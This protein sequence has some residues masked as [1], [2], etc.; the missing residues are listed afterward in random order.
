MELTK[1]LRVGVIGGGGIAQMMHLPFLAKNADRFEILALCDLSPKILSTIGDRF[2]V[3]PAMRFSSHL[4]LVRQDLDVVV[5]TSGGDHTPQVKAALEAGKHVFVEKPL[6]YSLKEV[7]EMSALAVRNDLKVMIGYMKRY[8]PGYHYAKKRLLEMGEIRY[9]Q[10]NTLHPE[11]EGYLKIHGLIA[12]DDVPAGVMQEI[13]QTQHQRILEAVGAIAPHLQAEY[14]DVLLGSM[15]HDINALRGLVGEPERVLFAEHWP[16]GEK[17]GGITTTIQYPGALRVV[18]TW[19]FLPELRNYFQEIALMSST[20]RL[21]IQFPSPYLRNFPTPVVVE[22]MKDGAAVEEKVIVSY[23]EAFEQELLA[24]YECVV[25]NRSP[26][27]DLA[28]AR[29]DIILLQQILAALHPAGLGGEA[30]AKSG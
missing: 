9:V 17:P 1:K 13:S 4:D 2:K 24:F 18:Y 29:R 15:I 16:A 21:R 22:S 25:S 10:I 11:E 28:D 20:N 23:E 14:T 12:A 19:I 8:D 7:D 26:L 30:A 27:T 3:P 6:C 5:I